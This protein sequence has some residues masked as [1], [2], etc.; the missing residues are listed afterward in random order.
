MPTRTLP[1]LLLLASA[2]LAAGEAPAFAI[3][4]Q[5]VRFQ[6]PCTPAC[7]VDVEASLQNA[8]RWNAQP[9][10]FPTLA[11]GIQV[12][13]EPGFAEFIVGGTL[14]VP[15]TVA[16]VEQGVLDAFGA[17]ETAELGFDVGFDALLPAEISVFA[18]DGRVHPFFEGNG[19]S[20]VAFV[21]AFSN[22]LMLTSG[23]LSY[24]RV[25]EGAEIYIAADRLWQSF[26]LWK[27]AGLLVEEDR[28]ARFT[29][30][31]IHEIGHTLGLH[32]Q[33][34]FPEYNFDDDGDPFTVVHPADPL[35]PWEGMAISANV[36]P[37]A[38]MRGAIP[39]DFASF[40]ATELYAD[41]RSGLNV[42]YPSL[43]EPAP[44]VLVLLA[45]VMLRAPVCRR[46]R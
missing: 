28:L 44:L 8:R 9:G 34:E 7:T 5:D 40:R 14:T 15:L 20:G 41:D 3:F 35:A 29:N 26:E 46:R 1:S 39:L 36:D 16:E 21:Q 45:G 31:M 19:F 6:A 18:V 2:L 23:A 10:A 25:I 27:L 12:A 11:D 42:L 37:N 38:I 30:L 33:N 4:P 32:H 17:W 43:P 24:G 22:P 13:V